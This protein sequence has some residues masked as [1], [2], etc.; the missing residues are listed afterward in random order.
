VP[1]PKTPEDRKDVNFSVKLAPAQMQFLKAMKEE[2]GHEAVA[3]VVREMVESFRTTFSLP[4]YQAE[5]LKA[6]RADRGMTS[7]QYVQELLAR[8][9]EELSKAAQDDAKVE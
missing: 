9:Y 4:P 3:D 2:L 8:R 5:R 7:L 6:D 1:R